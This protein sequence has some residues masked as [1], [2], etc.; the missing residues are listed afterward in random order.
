MISDTYK[1]QDYETATETDIYYQHGQQILFKEIK[2]SA[3]GYSTKILEIGGG[4]GVFADKLAHSLPNTNIQVIEPDQEWFS[5]LKARTS[6]FSNINC[7]CIAL[8]EFTGKSYDVC[9][10]SFALHH[11]PYQNLSVSINKISDMLKNGGRF[12]VLD[13]Y[14]PDFVNESERQSGLKTYHGYFLT[15]NKQRSIHK[16]IDFEIASLESNL[17]K[18]GDF[19]ISMKK[20]EGKCSKHFKLVK[21][22][23]IAPLISDLVS[24]A[25]IRENLRAA[26]FPV[27]EYEKR[28]IQSNLKSSNWGIFIHV[29]QKDE[30]QGCL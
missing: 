5:V 21:R 7:E 19:K 28:K 16:A 24:Q 6:R 13:K 10:A 1:L 12:L 18:A 29:F 3:K 15:C 20:F 22:I 23:K 8:K 17:L 4:S 11:I 26:G 9:Y 25:E 27:S 30:H 2:K 14:I